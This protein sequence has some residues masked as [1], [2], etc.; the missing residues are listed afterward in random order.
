MNTMWFS[1]K[2]W[3]VV[4]SGESCHPFRLKVYHLIL[5]H[6]F[7]LFKCQ[8]GSFASPLAVFFSN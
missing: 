5:I 8:G 3:N 7:Q 1:G 2:S 4:Y 6:I